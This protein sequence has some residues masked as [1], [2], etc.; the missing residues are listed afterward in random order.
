MKTFSPHVW[1]QW[2]LLHGPGCALVLG[3]SPLLGN[4][5]RLALHKNCW[6]TTISL[7]APACC[8]ANLWSQQIL[9]ARTSPAQAP[10]LA[11]SVECP[12]ARRAITAIAV[13]VVVASR[14]AA[15]TSNRFLLPFILNVVTPSTGRS[16]CPN[17]IAGR[18]IA[19]AAASTASPGQTLTLPVAAVVA[20]L[21]WSGRKPSSISKSGHRESRDSSSM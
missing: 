16:M 3:R 1:H 17:G 12:S 13:L 20:H 18:H 19:V 7:P 5:L 11:S 2:T 10:M 8:S 6:S 4:G 21:L 15:K 9:S 14:P